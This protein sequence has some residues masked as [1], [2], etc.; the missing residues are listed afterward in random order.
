VYAMGN[1]RME[2]D[3]GFSTGINWFFYPVKEA[4][5]PDRD[6]RVLT[7]MAVSAMVGVFA[8]ISGYMV[9]LPDPALSILTCV[10]N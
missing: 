1:L 7:T 8:G 5:P 9:I 2:E 3:S 4:P 6:K 10:V